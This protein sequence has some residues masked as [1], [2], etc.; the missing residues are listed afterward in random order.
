MTMKLIIE[1]SE[2]YQTYYIAKQNDLFWD[3]ELA[4]YLK[5]MLKNINN[6]SKKILMPKLNLCI[7][8][9]RLKKMLKMH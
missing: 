4:R 1:F 5:K 6:I 2:T 8:I 3:K 7:H 9:I